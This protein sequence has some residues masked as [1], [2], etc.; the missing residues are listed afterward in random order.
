MIR[1]IDNFR[2]YQAKFNT[3]LSQNN[4]SHR[5][6][7]NYLFD[8]SL[9]LGLKSKEETMFEGVSDLFSSRAIQSFVESIKT[10]GSS[11][12]TVNRRLAGIQLFLNFLIEEK[13]L[14]RNPIVTDSG[15]TPPA[16]PLIGE[17]RIGEEF[18]SPLPEK[19]GIGVRSLS[20][21]PLLR[22][23]K[24]GISHFEKYLVTSGLS[25]STIGDYVA[26]VE[27][28]L[29]VTKQDLPHLNPPLLA[30]LP[31]GEGEA[32]GLLNFTSPIRGGQFTGVGFT[33]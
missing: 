13:V 8:V 4:Y 28:F 32:R 7:K 25:R 21:P 11:E 9:Y 31:A 26:D 29:E 22:G 1:N 3:W 16:P 17:A 30:R 18:S 24:G 20:S 14:A 2:H 12:A 23:D 10:T 19:A 5:S 27:E 15:E 33:K 6:V